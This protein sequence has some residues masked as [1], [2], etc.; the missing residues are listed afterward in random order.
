MGM[1]SREQLVGF[2]SEIIKEFTRLSQISLAE[3]PPSAVE[4]LEALGALQERVRMIQVTLFKELESDFAAD[5][6]DAQIRRRSMR[7][8]VFDAICIISGE[9]SRF[10]SRFLVSLNPDDAD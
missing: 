7:A 10:R 6:E 4:F 8:Q 1:F 5:G 9:L 3:S 2:S